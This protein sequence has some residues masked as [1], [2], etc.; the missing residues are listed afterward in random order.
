MKIK[1]S[2]PVLLMILLLVACKNGPTIFEQIE[3][4][5]ELEDAVIVGSVNSIV[6]FGNKL[7]ASD[8]YIYSKDVEAIRGWSKIAS[9]QD[10]IIKLAADSS[11]LYALNRDKVLYTSTDG[12][13]WNKIDISGTLASIETIFTNGCDAAYIYG[14]AKDSK[15]KSY[16][17]LTGSSIAPTTDVTSYV[18]VKTDK[19]TYVANNGTVTG[20][21]SLGSVADLD[22][23]YALTYSAVDNA[24]YTGTK[25]GIKKLPLDDTGKL[26]GEK[27]NPPGNWQSTINAYEA[28]AVLATGT[29]AENAALYTSTIQK[30]STYAKIN[31]LWGYYYNRRS[32]WNRE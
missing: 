27:Q 26:T 10:T 12:T 9:P 29:N 1:H 4:E 25:K 28:F 13:T 3:Q 20:S 14:T 7:Y 31:G 21:N 32:S 11:N 30:S 18:L 19:G 8:G 2:I 16:F 22:T 5:I 23:I 17:T 6:Q 24:I 15:D